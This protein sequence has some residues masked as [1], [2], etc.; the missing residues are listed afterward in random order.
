MQAFADQPWGAACA[1]AKLREGQPPAAAEEDS[2]GCFIQPFQDIGDDAEVGEVFLEVTAA[3]L[4]DLEVLKQTCD[5]P[6]VHCRLHGCRSGHE[7]HGSGVIQMA[8]RLRAGDA[9][10]TATN[11]DEVEAIRVR[12]GGGLLVTFLR[13]IVLHEY[14]LLMRA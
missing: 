11:D 5:P 2:V 7:C 4:R 8:D 14:S 13:I 3:T 10:D 9:C 12:R 1:E 6:Q